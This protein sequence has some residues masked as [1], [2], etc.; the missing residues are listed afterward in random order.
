MDVCGAAGPAEVGDGVA[1]AP[2]GWAAGA[3]TRIMSSDTHL[4]QMLLEKM[5]TLQDSVHELQEQMVTF[6]ASVDTQMVTLQ[7]SV[8][9]VQASV[10]TLQRARPRQRTQSPHQVL[11]TAPQRRNHRQ[12]SKERGC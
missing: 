1:K 5:M 11:H 8:M 2:A 12:K 4:V 7:A 6:Q 10:K 9:S 3:T